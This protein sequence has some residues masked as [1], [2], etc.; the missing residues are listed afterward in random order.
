MNLIKSVWTAPDIDNFQ[1]FLI[2]QKRD[3]KVE[4]TKNSIRT[5]L[6]LLAITMPDLRKIVSQIMKGNAESFMEMQRHEFYENTIIYSLLIS[7]LK[8]T[9]LVFN[10]LNIIS[11][12]CDNWATCDVL[13]IHKSIHRNELFS[14]A[15][16]FTSSELPFKRRIGYRLFFDFISSDFVDRIFSAISANNAETHY[17]V[18]MIMA[19]LLCELFIKQR[20]K[21]LVFLQS[22]NLSK[23][24]I[25]KTVQKCRESFRVSAADKE[26][27]LAFKRK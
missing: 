11:S 13:S 4:W 25:N 21:T 12:V 17:Y 19:W 14:L 8:N 2:S 1:K 15:T 20:K 10:H 24:V 16:A 23:F 22:N 7:Q 26:M 5:S 3:D 27:L 6:P 9:S 18:N